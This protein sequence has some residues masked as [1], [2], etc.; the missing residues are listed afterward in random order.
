[1]K[2]TKLKYHKLKM[3]S[4]GIVLASTVGLSAW[5]I[6]GHSASAGGGGW[7]GGEVRHSLE[8]AT[9]NS[10][11]D[12][13]T[14]DVLVNSGRQTIASC[15]IRGGRFEVLA[16]PYNSMLYFRVV[17][18][19]D[20]YRPVYGISYFEYRPN[21]DRLV[22][23]DT[24]SDPHLH[25]VDRFSQSL[26]GAG[27]LLGGY[28][29][30]SISSSMQTELHLGQGGQVDQ[31]IT[32][33]RFALS[34]DGQVL[35]T[36]NNGRWLVR[37]NLAT[38]QARAVERYDSIWYD[39]MDIPTLLAASYDG[40]YA[41]LGPTARIIDA[42]SGCGTPD[43]SES[44]FDN[45]CPTRDLGHGPEIGLA[46]SYLAQTAKFINGDQSAQVAYWLDTRWG[47]TYHD[48]SAIYVRATF[49]NSDYIG[50]SGRL[51]YLALGDSYSSGEG[52]IGILAGGGSYYTE[53]SLDGCHISTRSYPYLLAGF[54]NTDSE[55][56]RSIACSGA[57]LRSDFIPGDGAYQGQRSE[58]VQFAGSYE[59]YASQALNS[60]L[61]GR[62]PQLEFVK[63]YQPKVITVTASGNDVG[64]A[65]IL[66]YC[67]SDI[68]KE[69]IFGGN[70]GFVDGWPMHDL[71]DN[72]IDSQYVLVKNLVSSLRRLD[73]DAKIYYIGYPSFIADYGSICALNSGVLNVD[74]REM[75]N[76]AVHRLNDVIRRAAASEGASYVDIEDVLVG[77]RLC[78]GSEYMTG[79]WDAG[80]GNI[81][82]GHV[83]QE[84][85]HP[86]A[87]GHQRIA[88]K[89]YGAVANPY[90]Y[91][92]SIISDSAP[93]QPPTKAAQAT[94]V[95]GSTARQGDA[96]EVILTPGTV[97]GDPG[98]EVEIYLDSV[99]LGSRAP[100]V[101]GSLSVD[102][103]LPSETQVGDH[104]IMVWVFDDFRVNPMGGAT[105]YYQYIK[106]LPPTGSEP[107]D[108]DEASPAGEVEDSQNND[109]ESDV[110]NTSNN[111]IANQPSEPYD[112]AGD[113]GGQT[114]T[115]V[116]RYSMS[117]VDIVP[118]L[119]A[120]DDAPSSNQSAIAIVDT[121]PDKSDSG[122]R[123]DGEVL[124]QM[125]DNYQRAS[126]DLTVWLLW[127]GVCLTVLMTGYVIMSIIRRRA[128]NY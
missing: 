96:V 61:P 80:I 74:E 1:M 101:D 75:I 67:A 24:G 19:N 5:Y 73:S 8:V 102:I 98:M 127:G 94:L 57:L 11:C 93:T 104:I 9:D 55:R 31:Y 120:S 44:S 26:I 13:E 108:G 27:S 112:I 66:N 109:V 70:C 82:A 51:A 89:V 69:A 105:Q 56:A 17:G 35:Y 62:I 16:A 34:G 20:V 6:V 22:Y 64:F 78:E 107:A 33:N 21:I 110:K 2:L 23:K 41:I 81:L 99:Y 47:Q 72:T 91:T 43:W 111:D 14:V 122:A 113:F 117:D 71:L 95:A 83:P 42:S 52:D 103:D 116:A 124:G 12:R 40:S 90:T 7:L 87:A 77:G 92:Q 53:D 39:G 25:V 36:Y 63:R 121:S 3:A 88:E 65:N 85:F 15:V 79:I 29:M 68:A 84:V 76:T 100:N 46:H 50:E 48:G 126:D 86:N 118:W 60:F 54:W 37:V 125:T 115:V 58:L 32:T 123:A 38:G 10:I 18:S 97:P 59:Q 114:P 128:R 4:L 119:E 30:Y 106:V 45:P 28:S 49:H